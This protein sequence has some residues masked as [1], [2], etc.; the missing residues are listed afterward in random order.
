MKHKLMFGAAFMATWL[1]I[2]I[3]NALASHCSIGQKGEVL[4]KGNWYS[5]KV[6]D[7]DGD[8]CYITYDG[9]DS[10]WDEWVEPQRFRSAYRVGDSV[11]I[12]WQGQWYPGQI[13]AISGNSYQITYYGYDSS[14]NEWVES[15]RLSR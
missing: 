10:S 4:W 15:S 7:V 1:G 14:W 8:Y 2:M 9:Y 13:L 3:P 11:K 12:Y 5:A 6:L